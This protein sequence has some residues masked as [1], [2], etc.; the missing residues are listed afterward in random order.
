MNAPSS[1]FAQTRDPRALRDSLSCFPTGVTVVTAR[2][3]D[4]APVGVTVSSFNA[5]SLDPPLIL[6]SLGLK[7]ASL[8][9]FRAADHFAVNVLSEAQADLPRIF[10]SPVEDR[11]AGLDWRDGIGGA[12][13]LT[14]S[15][16]VFECRSYARYDGG[17][18]EIMLGEVMQHDWREAAPLIF[19][20]GRVSTLQASE[21]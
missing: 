9:V 12:P 16:A 2:A 10:S 20:K 8:E 11:F 13:V 4:G 21:T 6:W 5:V 19:A 18:H 3:Q 7:S 15:T 1:S 17:D 14:D